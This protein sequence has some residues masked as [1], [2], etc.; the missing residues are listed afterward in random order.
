MK[1]LDVEGQRTFTSQNIKDEG[2]NLL[3]DP[4]LIRGRWARWFHSCLNT[5]S[6]TLDPRV[7]DGVRSWPEDAQLDTVPSE[8]EVEE[9]VRSMANRKAV[10]PDE[11]PAELLKVLLDRN[12]APFQQFYI[13]ARAAFDDGSGTPSVKKGLDQ[14]AAQEGQ[15]GV[16]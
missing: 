8:D 2:G 4:A 16:R 3:R 13:I 6:P 10:G 9:A 5:K 14:S 7:V 1:R 11:L 15:D 12:R